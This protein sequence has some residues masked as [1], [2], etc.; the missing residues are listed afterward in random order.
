MPHNV[1]F[2]TTDQQRTDSVSCYGSSFARTPALDA[3]A[4]RG[5]RFDRAYCTNPVC[6]PSRASILA[7]TYLSRHGAWNVGMNVPSD[8]EL[9]SHRLKAVGYRTHLIGK[10]HFNAFGGSP[11]QSAEC[12][13]GW[14]DRFPAFTGPYYGFNGV[15]LALGHTT[16]GVA[17]HYGAWVEQK[18]GRTGDRLF[19]SRRRAAAPF[20]GEAYDWDIPLELHSSTWTADRVC[21]FLE[22]AA[23]NERPFFLSVGF[24]DPHHAHALPVEHARTLDVARFPAPRY[25]EGELDDKPPYFRE[26]REGNLERSRFRGA[27]HV[28]GQGPGHDYRKV[29]PDDARLGRAYYHGMVEL[30][31]R[32]MGRILQTLERTGLDRSTLVVFTTD[33]GELLGDHGLW[34]KGPFHYEELVRVPLIVQLPGRAHA[35]RVVGSVVSLA[36][37]APTALSVAGFPVPE[38]LDGVDLAPV[39]AARQAAHGAVFVEVVDDPGG[40]RLKTVVTERYKL[41]HCHGERFGELYDLEADPGEIVNRWADPGLAGVRAE[42]LARIID[43]SERLEPRAA[44]YD[45]A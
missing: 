40:I 14:R 31:D 17:G 20:G 36:D 4:G 44:R 7:G 13:K 16:Y 28:A 8:V 23:G 42:L 29:T 10:A 45:Y 18:I 1:I 21:A 12:L 43:F 38:G 22:D 37:L 25:R 34:M 2:I 41:T 24:E 5:V 26:A 30:I 19:A 27:F 9:L 33:H 3:M 6:T 11:E 39:I 35:G 32:A 15:E